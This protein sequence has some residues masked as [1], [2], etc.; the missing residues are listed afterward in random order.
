MTVR[1]ALQEAN[2][3]QDDE[4]CVRGVHQEPP[5]AAHTLVRAAAQAA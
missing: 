3:E 5:P 4:G 2:G 1:T